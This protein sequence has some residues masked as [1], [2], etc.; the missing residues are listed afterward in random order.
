MAKATEEV[1]E[2]TGRSWHKERTEEMEGAVA[3]LGGRGTWGSRCCLC[4]CDR[5]RRNHSSS[6]SVASATARAF[7]LLLAAFCLPIGHFGLP[8][9]SILGFISVSTPLQRKLT[10]KVPL[11]GPPRGPKGRVSI[12]V[13]PLN[14]LDLLTGLSASLGCREKT[15]NLENKFLTD[16]LASLFPCAAPFSALPQYS[17][18]CYL[19][20]SLFSFTDTWLPDPILPGGL[21][22]GMLRSL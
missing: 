1:P 9:T 13:C 5:H 10:F 11:S 15:Q 17:R 20:L 19:L 6:V 2:A 22:T 16:L 21:S 4:G 7:G 3:V 14:N 12:H 8:R 18:P